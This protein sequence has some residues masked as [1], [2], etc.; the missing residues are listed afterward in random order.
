MRGYLNPAR[1]A[2][3]DPPSAPAHHPA[4]G[5]TPSTEPAA[6]GGSDRTAP[7]PGMGGRQAAKL[8]RAQRAGVGG[9]G[10]RSAPPEPAPLGGAA[11]AAPKPP[12]RAG[13]P[14]SGAEGGGRGRSRSSQQRRRHPAPGAAPW[15]GASIPAG[16]P[17]PP[18]ATPCTVATSRRPG[19]PAPS[20]RRRSAGDQLQARP[21]TGR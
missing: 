15:A 5:R 14:R 1:P 9:A 8:R 20:W 13:A 12:R 16:A 4:A 17:G 7:A 10:R 21:G 11:R 19:P 6:A 2:A 18:G 3:S